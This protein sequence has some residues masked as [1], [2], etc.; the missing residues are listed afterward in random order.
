M[1]YY[2]YS[3]KVPADDDTTLFAPNVQV[4]VMFLGGDK[5]YH[6]HKYTR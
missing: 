6:Q 4:D 1:T 2:M 3:G 5:C